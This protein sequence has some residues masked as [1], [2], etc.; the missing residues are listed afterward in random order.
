MIAFVAILVSFAILAGLVWLLFGSHT[1]SPTATI[2]DLDIENVIPVN[3]RHFPQISRLLSREDVQFIRN[4]APYHMERKWRTERRAIL[5]QYLSGLRQDFTRLEQLARLI[6]AL[7]PEI[8]N[9]QEWGW[10]WLSLQFSLSYRIVAL[11]LALGSFSPEGLTGLTDMIAGLAG[12]LENRMALIAEA[13]PSRL[14][15]DVSA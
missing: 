6:A 15:A 1:T 5:K 10:I 3:S 8:R 14:R 4:R 9:R 13:S 12:E 11:K 2:G 7:S